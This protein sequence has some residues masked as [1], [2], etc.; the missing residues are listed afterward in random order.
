MFAMFND[1]PPEISRIELWARHVLM[2]TE[3]KSIEIIH[4]QQL[5]DLMLYSCLK[6]K[7]ATGVAASHS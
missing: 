5:Q 6:K 2:Q 4:R 7:A 1:R 3:V